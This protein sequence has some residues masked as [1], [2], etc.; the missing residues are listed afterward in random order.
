MLNE[1]IAQKHVPSL[2][3]VVSQSDTLVDGE[4]EQSRKRKRGREGIISPIQRQINDL[5]AD[6]AKLEHEHQMQKI[7]KARSQ[8]AL[9]QGSVD[10]QSAMPLYRKEV[11]NI[12][13]YGCAYCSLFKAINWDNMRQHAKQ[14]HN[15][16]APACLQQKPRM[17]CA[18]QR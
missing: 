17:R 12:S 18:L 13:G 1:T 4:N 14:K 8:G 9:T 15:I 7:Y 6:L 2:D 16:S 10:N 5:R 11:H 3:D